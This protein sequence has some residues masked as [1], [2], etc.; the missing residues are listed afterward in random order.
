MPLFFIL[1]YP[2]YKTQFSLIYAAC[3]LT[4]GV[5]SVN[6]GGILA[7]RFAKKNPGAYGNICLWSSMLGWP[8]MCLAVLCTSN[9]YVSIAAVAASFFLGS[10]Y[11]GPN[12]TMMQKG[13]PSEEFGSYISAYNFTIS[14]TACVSTALVGFVINYF[15]A[16]SNPVMIGR[17]IAGFLCIG[18]G[19]SI[20]A[21]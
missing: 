17:V 16:G 14:M 3:Y 9:F 19:G 10:T 6:L 7:D 15:N 13:I 1:Q 8:T 12:V 11:W 18:Y 5:A 2:A 20:W 21:W 4:L